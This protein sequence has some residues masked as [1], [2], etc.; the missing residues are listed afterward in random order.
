[1]A[2][3]RQ[4]RC[5]MNPILLSLA[6]MMMLL[7]IQ[8]FRSGEDLTSSW[9][10]AYILFCAPLVIFWLSSLLISNNLAKYLYVTSWLFVLLTALFT[11]TNGAIFMPVTA[12]LALSLSLFIFFL[13]L[14]FKVIKVAKSRIQNT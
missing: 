10:F 13:S 3:Y 12:W 1:M 6:T 8:Y 7:F 14:I 11:I 9:M 5:I 4:V 2:S